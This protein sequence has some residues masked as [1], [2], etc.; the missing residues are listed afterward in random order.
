[1]IFL[2]PTPY[3]CTFENQQQPICSWTQD[4]SD[5]FN[6]TPKVGSTGSL[7][8]GPTFDHTLQNRNGKE[9]NNQFE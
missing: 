1:L 9:I 7:N 3:D 5:Q 4:T 8:T 6:W 2:A